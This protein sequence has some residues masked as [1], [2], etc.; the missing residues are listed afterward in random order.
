MNNALYNCIH[1]CNKNYISLTKQKLKDKQIDIYIRQTNIIFGHQIY[2]LAC[3]MGS[4][5]F[6]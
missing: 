3:M 1:D 5:F 4:C 6:H 2:R